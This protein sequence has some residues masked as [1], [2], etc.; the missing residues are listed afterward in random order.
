MDDL[1]NF[2]EVLNDFDKNQVG[3]RNKTFL[4][5]LYESIRSLHLILHGKIEVR[6]DKCNVLF[7]TVITKYYS[8]EELVTEI[9]AS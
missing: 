7:R 8:F 2:M 4:L 9:T 6:T 1:T 3:N 5:H